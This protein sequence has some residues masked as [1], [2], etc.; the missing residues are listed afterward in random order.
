MKVTVSRVLYVA[1]VVVFAA[2]GAMWIAA[3]GGGGRAT[4]H[5][6]WQSLTLAEITV[7]LLLR[8]HKPVGTLAGILAAYLVFDLPWL[9]LPPLLFALLTVAAVRDRRTVAVAAAAVAAVIVVRPYLQRDPGGVAGY[10]LL[11][12]AAAGVVIAAGMYARARMNGPARLSRP[13]KLVAGILG[14]EA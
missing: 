7:A 4:T 10:S 6:M 5:T 11:L 3:R 8:R 14:C 12:L 13:G 2:Y 1:P 9:T